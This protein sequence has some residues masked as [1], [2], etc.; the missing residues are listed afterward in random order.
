MTLGEEDILG[1]ASDK[2]VSRKA[3]ITMTEM[4]KAAKK[5]R[6]AFYLIY[7]QFVDRV[8]AYTLAKVGSHPDAEDLTSE[9]FVRAIQHL[10]R[11]REKGSFL[12]WLLTIA[13]NLTFDHYRNHDQQWLDLEEVALPEQNKG[14]DLDTQLFLKSHLE[15][16]NQD[17]LELLILRYTAGLTFSEIGQVIGK[18]EDAVRKAHNKV[19]DKLRAQMEEQDD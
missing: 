12:A 5:D 3:A 17:E 16:L 9:V 1:S 8:Y 10:N 15:N 19:L 4:L 7:L 18:K 14:I 2:R 11:Y 6:A 13:R